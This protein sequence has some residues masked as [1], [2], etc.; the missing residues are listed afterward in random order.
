LDDW[1]DNKKRIFCFF[2]NKYNIVLRDE[3]DS[4]HH[5]L[6]CAK[7]NDI[8]LAAQFTTVWVICYGQKKSGSV[9]KGAKADKNAKGFA[10]AQGAYNN[11]MIGS[12][13]ALVDAGI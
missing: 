2:G 7:G 3:N 8:C 4:G 6:V 13:D 5:F 10:G 11:L 1:K 12:W 9:K